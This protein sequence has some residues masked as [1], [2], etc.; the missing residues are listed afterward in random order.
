LRDLVK[1]LRR[2]ALVAASG[3]HRPISGHWGYDRGQPIDR[4]YIERFLESCSADVRGDALEV[5]SADYVRRYG[6]AL[7]RVEVLDVDEANADATIIGD[8]SGAPFVEAESF[9]CFV[10]TQTLQYVFDLESAVR[11]AHRLLRPGGVLLVTV[12]ALA[13]LT[14]ELELDDFWRFTSASLR[15]LLEPVFGPEVQIAARGNLVSSIA[16]LTGLAAGELTERELAEDDLRFPVLVTARA[17]R[18]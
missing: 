1:S 9:D 2:R 4:W 12:P 17:V 5:K 13:R 18:G 6:S 7:Q 11:N 3:I 14:H 10:L 8:L 16:F 15:R